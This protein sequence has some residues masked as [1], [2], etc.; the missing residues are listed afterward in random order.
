MVKRSSATVFTIKTKTTPIRA[1][2]RNPN[3][4]V[5]S[6]LNTSDTNILFGYDDTVATSGR[7]KGWTI[8]SGG[9][10]VED[11][12]SKSDVYIICSTADKSITFQEVTEVEEGG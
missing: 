12:H 3:R 5:W 8:Y 7:A 1:L 4:V 10:S 6:A 2:G 9:G 11:E